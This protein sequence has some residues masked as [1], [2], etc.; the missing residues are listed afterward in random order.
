MSSESVRDMALEDHHKAFGEVAFLMDIFTATI[1][2][3]MG[4]ATA[5]VGR[6]AG[7]E[8]AKKLP[9]TL[10]NPSL[11]DAVGVVAVRMSA[12][13]GVTL[14]GTDGN[15]ELVFDRCALREVCTLRGIQ[16]GGALCRLFHAYFDGILNELICRPVKSELVATGDSCR[17]TVSTQ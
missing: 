2:N 16:A 7:R 4:G 6:F 1:D 13:F 3:I 14:E 15:R 5:P 17:A 12:G 9:I 8:M 11:E 10:D